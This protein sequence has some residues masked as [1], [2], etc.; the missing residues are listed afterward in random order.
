MTT[1]QRAQNCRTDKARSGSAMSGG[2]KNPRG[3]RRHCTVSTSPNTC[4]L[5]KLYTQLVTHASAVAVLCVESSGSAMAA[6][7]SFLRWRMKM[8]M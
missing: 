8:L 1:S 5:K 4:K 2:N 6:A 7:S 3:M